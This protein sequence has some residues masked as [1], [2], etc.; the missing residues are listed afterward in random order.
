MARDETGPPEP[1]AGAEPAHDMIGPG[2]AGRLTRGAGLAGLGFVVTRGLTFA[3]YIVLA[4]LIEPSDAG[5]LAAG[6]VLI[7][8]GFVL[9]ESGMLAALIHWKDDVDEAASTATVST[10]VT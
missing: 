9:A 1:P 6:M 7:G 8:A 2:M 3:T 4:Q 5:E 10:V